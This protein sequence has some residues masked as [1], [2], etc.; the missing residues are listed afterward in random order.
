MIPFHKERNCYDHDEN[1]LRQDLADFTIDNDDFDPTCLI[2]KYWE[3]VRP[4]LIEWVESA[5]ELYHTSVF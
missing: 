5:A 1:L 2:G 4:V 3:L